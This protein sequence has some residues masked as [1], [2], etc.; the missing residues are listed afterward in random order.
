[1]FLNLKEPY[2]PPKNFYW[3]EKPLPQKILIMPRISLW[4]VH[5]PGCGTDRWQKQYEN[6]NQLAETFA[7]RTPMWKRTSYS[8]Q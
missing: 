4:K 2:T 7:E 3:V 1:M 5:A 8:S 6:K